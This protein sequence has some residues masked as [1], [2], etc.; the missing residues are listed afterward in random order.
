[1][2][3]GIVPALVLLLAAGAGHAQPRLIPQ[4]AAAVPVSGQSI[5]VVTNKLRNDSVVI[6]VDGVRQLH[7]MNGET[8]SIVVPNGR[9][10]VEAVQFHWNSG[11]NSWEERRGDTKKINFKG[12]VI[13]VD[14]ESGPDITL[15]GKSP[16]DYGAADA[17]EAAAQAAR[18]A[19]ARAFG[20]DTGE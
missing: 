15:R 4:R 16:V 18:E 6:A 11:K 19:A 3:R 8:A 17:A 7:L 10:T 9:R 12:Q 14:V 1:M 5:V 13:A 2:K 20:D